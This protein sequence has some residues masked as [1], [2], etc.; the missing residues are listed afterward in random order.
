MNKLLLYKEE[1][2]RLESIK[3]L[4]FKCAQHEQQLGGESPLRAW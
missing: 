3:V 4:A 1:N 2:K